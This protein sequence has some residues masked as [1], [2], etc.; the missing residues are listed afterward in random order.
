MLKSSIIS[1]PIIWKRRPSEI[2]GYSR[3]LYATT[4]SGDYLRVDYNLKEKKVRIYIEDV[5][6]GGNPYYSVI[7]NGSITVERNATTGRI[8][9]LFEKLNKRASIFST[10]PVKEVIKQINTN[11]GIGITKGKKNKEKEETEEEKKRKE[12]AKKSEL[13]ETRRKYFK[14]E[15]YPDV[16]PGSSAA[17]QFES[18]VKKISIQDLIDFTVGVLACGAIYFYTND[19][20]ILGIVSSAI[21]VFTGFVDVFFRDRDPMFLKVLLFIIAGLVSYIYGYFYL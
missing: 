10:I 20:V 12:Q 6:E 17:G 18:A 2:S 9:S 7:N 15:D 14:P 21:G 4:D 19:Y 1:K 5:D 8:T 13:E 3:V 11:Y 16:E